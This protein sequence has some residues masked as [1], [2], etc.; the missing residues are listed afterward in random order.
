MKLKKAL[1][2]MAMASFW[3][4]SAQAGLTVNNW[5]LNTT[6][7]AVEG[8]TLDRILASV[9]EMTF[10]AIAKA[11]LTTDIGAPGL[12][13]GDGL[14][15][16]V[17]GVV[18]SFINS[19]AP[20]AALGV[21]S[22]PELN[23]ESSITIGGTTF[24]GWELTFVYSGT[25]TVEALDAANLGQGHN[26]GGTLKLYIDD[27]TNGGKADQNVAGSYSNGTLVYSSTDDGTGSGNFNFPSFDG[28]DDG[29]FLVSA[30]DALANIAGVFTQ[31]T[32]DFGKVEGSDV[33]TDSNF[34]ADQ[35]QDGLLNTTF[36]AL[37]PCGSTT[38]SFC[39]D[40]N[41]SATLS[42][43]PEPASLALL[44]LGLLGMGAI[45]R[46]RTK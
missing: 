34:F 8:G 28:N 26:P 33:H 36:G 35:D 7:G 27:L 2:T 42:K 4:S 10:Q 44:G 37:A 17:L 11:D 5:D 1:L 32:Y 40:E 29:H 23:S 18:T 31:G 13:I 24:T 16:S 25:S 19:A 46:R 41:G 38:S 15:T 12:S 21:I 45:R 22:V 20:P 6:L 30:A 39:A 3:A 14:T 43:V 9:D